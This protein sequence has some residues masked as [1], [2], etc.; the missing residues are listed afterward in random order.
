M[1]TKPTLV[2]SLLNLPSQSYVNAETKPKKEYYSTKQEMLRIAATARADPGQMQLPRGRWDGG[3]TPVGNDLPISATAMS[4]RKEPTLSAAFQPSTLARTQYRS[5]GPH[6]ED[7]EDDSDLEVFFTPNTSPRTSMASSVATITFPATRKPSRRSLTNITADSHQPLQLPVEQKVSK[8][9]STRPFAAVPSTRTPSTS[10]SHSTRARHALSSS[11]SLS[12][13]SLEGHSVFSDFV[14]SGES[15]LLT[16]PYQSD[17]ANSTPQA[18]GKSST[19][20]VDII[21]NGAS[22]TTNG[23]SRSHQHTEEERLKES[24]RM[25]PSTDSSKSRTHTT[26]PRAP[27]TTATQNS[28]G[29]SPRTE[30]PSAPSSVTDRPTKKPSKSP[31]PNQPDVGSNADVGDKRAPS[32]TSRAAKGKEKEHTHEE[33]E[34]KPTSRVSSQGTSTSTGTPHAPT[35]TPTKPYV[36]PKQPHTFSAFASI[37]D[38]SPSP[39]VAAPATSKKPSSPANGHG[40]PSKISAALS[41]TPKPSPAPSHSTR[42]PA[43]VVTAKPPQIPPVPS[44]QPPT[45]SRDAYTPTYAYSSGNPHHKASSTPPNGS[46]NSKPGAPSSSSSTT[47]TQRRKPAVY[48]PPP[49]MM[50]GMDALLEEDEDGPLTPRMESRAIEGQDGWNWEGSSDGSAGRHPTQDVDGGGGDNSRS[51]GLR[52]TSPEHVR[53]RRSRS[54]DND[55][56]SSSSHSTTRAR[57]P[58]PKTLSDEVHALVQ[59]FSTPG[60]RPSKGTQGY[61]ALVLPRAPPPLSSSSSPRPLKGRDAGSGWLAALALSAEGRIDLTQSGVAQTTMATVEVVRGLGSKAA[62]G[63]GFG[64][65]FVRRRAS[66]GPGPRQGQGPAPVPVPREAT[67][68]RA[69]PPAGGGWEGSSSPLGFTSYRTPPNY[70]PSSGVLVQVWAVGVDGVDGRLVGVRFGDGEV[71]RGEDEPEDLDAEVSQQ[72]DREE[73]EEDEG[74]GD[75][76]TGREDGDDGAQ[77]TETE[78]AEAETPSTPPKKSGG[79]AALGRSLSLRLSRGG[80]SKQKAGGGGAKPQRSASAAVAAAAAAASPTKNARGQS[81]PPQETVSSSPQTPHTN[82][83]KRS[84]SFS[85]KRS[86]TAVS[87]ASTLASP[88]PS[89]SA[90]PGKQKKKSLKKKAPPKQLRPD[91]GYIPGRSFVGRVLECG[92]GVRD[93]VVRKGE[94]VVGLLDVRKVRFFFFFILR[95]GGALAE[96]I[97]VDRRRVHRVPQ[98]QGGS[99]TNPIWAASA[100]SGY[101]QSSTLTLEELALLPLCGLPAYRAVRTFMYAFSSMRDGPSSPS[102]ADRRGLDF[103]GNAVTTSAPSV[104]SPGGKTRR[105]TLPEHDVDRRRRVLVLRGHDGVGAMAVQ[106]LAERGWKVSVHV[107]CSAMPADAPPQVVDHFMQLTEE[108][109]RAW[110]ADEIIH[111]DSVA[112]DDGRAAAVRL[113]EMIREDGDVFDA[114]LD[115]VGGREVREAGERLLRSQGSSSGA[116]SPR[117]GPSAPMKR[118]DHGQFTTL[119]GDAPQRVVPT[120]GDNFRAGL[121]SLRLGGADSTANGATS[122]ATKSSEDS[123]SGKVGYAWISVAQDVDWEGVDVGETLGTVVRMALEDGVRPVVEDMDVR[124][125]GSRGVPRAVPFEYTPNVF[126]DNGPLRDGGTIVVKIAE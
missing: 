124:W 72:T 67:N 91:V 114:V 60:E 110:G 6:P 13:T 5:T 77:D 38:A 32:S 76:E 56:S 71:G 10:T 94:W 45:T 20:K 115:T 116:A 89:S 109:A 31:T 59:G 57:H 80:S 53:R 51:R 54:L 107:P 93:E 63:F 17:S 69:V 121:R 125:K 24:K 28:S 1:P 123:G 86:N 35:A 27:T 33:K 70:V 3:A 113:M 122:G 102:T 36:P 96:F 65:G 126:V 9:P 61:T 101:A 21:G 11:S 103:V 47:T 66:S 98:P 23:K 79:F 15:T 7:D 58:P 26:S 62:R 19:T 42:A 22:P 55:S 43:T 104:S 88:T 78:E 75:E 8:T 30:K 83:H 74:R 81:E 99:A 40:A 37:P 18:K 12:S 117:E 90:S 2:Q 111:D 39:P 14:G 64:L 16:T 85:L 29:P 120:A 44:Q 34:K 92:W 118:R 105:G 49:S 106:M 95:C 97:V 46:A 112:G 100:S 4:T 119:V 25:P 48:K 52:H 41:S 73:T 68:G 108:R 84:L 82:G 87:N 50:I